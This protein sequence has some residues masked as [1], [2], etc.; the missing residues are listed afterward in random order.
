MTRYTK[1]SNGHYLI[2][3]KKYEKLEGSRAQVYH[4]TAY[5]TSGNLKKPEIMMNKN[6]RIVSKRKH[7]TA[8]KE[9]R[10][11]RAGYGTKKGKFGFVKIGKMKIGKSKKSRKGRSKKMRGGGIDDEEEYVGSEEPEEHEEPEL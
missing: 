3:G 11:I 8:K 1:T 4:G 7:F 10:L 5:K 6:H 2:H 9:R